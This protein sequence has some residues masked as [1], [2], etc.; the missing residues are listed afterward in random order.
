MLHI[1][2]KKLKIRCDI[3]FSNCIGIFLG[4]LSSVIEIAW[5]I[6]M[7]TA[8]FIRLS[9]TLSM[10]IVCIVFS[11]SLMFIAI[12]AR[13]FQLLK[14]TGLPETVAIFGVISG[15]HTSIHSDGWFLGTLVGWL[16]SKTFH[17]NPLEIK[18][19]TQSMSTNVK[20]YCWLIST[21]TDMPRCT[22]LQYSV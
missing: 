9:P 20:S 5:W 15:L 3:D 7:G 16:I 21:D 10:I 1:A 8:P 17:S 19:Q 18:I 4:G 22:L 6:F 2:F 13:R 14:C 12:C 11:H